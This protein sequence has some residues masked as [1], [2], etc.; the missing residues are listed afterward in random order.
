MKILTVDDDRL[1][2]MLLCRTLEKAGYGTEQADSVKAA[3]DIL[4]SGEP[5]ILMICDL[6]M[7]GTDGLS[8]LAEIRSTPSMAELPVLV[9]TAQDPARWYDA[10]DCLGISG[11][12]AKP[13]NAQELVEKVST[14]L[15]SAIVPID[16]ASTVQR[17][18]QISVEDYIESLE[19]LEADLQSARENVEKCTAETDFEKLETN[20][21]GLAGAARS[22]GALRLGPVL[23]TLSN[24]CR[25]KDAAR[26]QENGAQLTRE[27]R[28]LQSALEVMRHEQAR[29]KSSSKAGNYYLPMARGMIWKQSAHKAE[30][31]HFEVN[32]KTNAH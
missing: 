18:L 21:D 14:A 8:F 13:L 29:F 11:Y 25:E 17:R 2:R 1:S 4:Q 28:I 3:K 26:L 9:C 19:G 30:N 15:E 31:G 10:A 27:I 6:T 22:L 20:L 7:P 24:T 23:N 32:F 5:V 16:D 12:I